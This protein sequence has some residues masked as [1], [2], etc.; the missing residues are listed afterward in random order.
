[1]H[2]LHEIVIQYFTSLLFSNIHYKVNSAISSDM[3]CNEI[4]LQMQN[5][6]FLWIQNFSNLM[7][8]FACGHS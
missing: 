3:Y 1:M 5:L 6:Y 2:I 7:C 4:S 8:S